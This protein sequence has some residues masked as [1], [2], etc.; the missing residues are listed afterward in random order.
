[1]VIFKMTGVLVCPLDLKDIITRCLLACP[2]ITSHD[3][4]THRCLVR[5][6]RLVFCFVRFSPLLA[7]AT[8]AGLALAMASDPQDRQVVLRLLQLRGL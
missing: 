4:K 1:M 3:R 5:F 2:C 6:T 7:A 8:A